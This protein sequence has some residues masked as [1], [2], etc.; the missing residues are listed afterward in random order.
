[1]LNCA[2]SG[3]RDSLKP[4]SACFDDEYN[5]YIGTPTSPVIELTVIILPLF[6]FFIEGN[7][8]RIA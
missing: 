6:R 1:M 5:P 2:S 8:A 3:E 7:T 4:E